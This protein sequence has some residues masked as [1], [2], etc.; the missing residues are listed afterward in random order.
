MYL[1]DNA[2]P[3]RQ[4]NTY[5]E[6]EN[7]YF[8][9]EVTTGSGPLDVDLKKTVVD[10]LWEQTKGVIQAFN[11]WMI[12]FLK[13]FGVK[14]GNILSPFTCNFDTP[15]DLIKLIEDTLKCLQC[16]LRDVE[17]DVV[18]IDDNDINADDEI[19]SSETHSIETLNGNG[20]SSTAYSQFQE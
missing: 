2:L 5:M 4:V 8:P 1:R 18:S 7:D 19:P 13:L 20:D 10:Q 9:K 17:P 12:P 15:D 6:C 3:L 16:D 11:S 14:K